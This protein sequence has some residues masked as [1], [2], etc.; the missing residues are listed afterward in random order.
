LLWVLVLVVL[1]SSEIE[2]NGN[3]IENKEVGSKNETPVPFRGA[4]LLVL[5]VLLV[6]L[7]VGDGTDGVGG[8]GDCSRSDSGEDGDCGRGASSSSIKLAVAT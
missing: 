4:D 8:D 5:L 1:F 3:G 7:T 2:G 6:L